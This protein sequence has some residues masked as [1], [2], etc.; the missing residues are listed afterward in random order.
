M[1]ICGAQ[2]GQQQALILMIQQVKRLVMQSDN[3][4]KETLTTACCS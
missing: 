3:E 4:T 2:L 1:G